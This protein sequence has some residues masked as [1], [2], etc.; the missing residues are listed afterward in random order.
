MCP[1][2]AHTCHGYSRCLLLVITEDGLKYASELIDCC[3]KGRPCGMRF[4]KCTLP[5]QGKTL[6]VFLMVG[7][8]AVSGIR[9]AL[10][11]S[12]SYLPMRKAG[13]IAMFSIGILSLVL[14]AIRLLH[15]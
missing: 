5:L 13:R 1:G 6:G 2:F 15:R 7:A 9:G 11:F 8:F 14:G 10:A 4:L 3:V 12:S